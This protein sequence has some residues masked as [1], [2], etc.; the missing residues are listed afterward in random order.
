VSE[1]TAFLFPGQG[2]LPASLP[3]QSTELERLYRLVERDGPPLRAWIET[4]DSRLSD[5]AAAQPLIFLDSLTRLEGL[6]QRGEAVTAAAGHSLGEYAAL[7]CCGVISAS[8]AARLV[9]ERGRLMSGVSGGMAAILRLNAETVASLCRSVGP[10][11]VVANHNGP[12]QIVVS[13]RDEAVERV[14]VLAEERGA[15]AIRLKV[16][17]PFHS[18]FMGP[19][20]EALRP[21]IE[22]TPFRAPRVPF[23]SSISGCLESSPSR[24]K[25]LLST[26]ITA[27]VLWVETIRSLAASGVLCAV[28]VG[29]GSVLTNMGKRITDRITFLTYEEAL[30]G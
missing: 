1:R 18:P 16:S 2:Q 28:E 12:E 20:E 24:L 29:P 22:E 8:D 4:A 19:A 14:A 5:T 9:V 21:R 15:R 23:V 10:D 25:Q 11:V 7:V 17:G 26:Q 6:R 3:A 13:G 27:P 30:H